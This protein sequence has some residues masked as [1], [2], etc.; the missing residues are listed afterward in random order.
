MLMT[1][2]AA[3]GQDLVP[4]LRPRLHHGYG[5][6]PRYPGRTVGAG[7]DYHLTSP[8]DTDSCRLLGELTKLR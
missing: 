7:F 5:A 4:A 1:I 8:V 2:T 3:S 6:R